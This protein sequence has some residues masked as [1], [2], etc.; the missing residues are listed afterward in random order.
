MPFVPNLWIWLVLCGFELADDCL[1]QKPSSP[2][3]PIKLQ[4]SISLVWLIWL[5]LGTQKATPF[6]VFPLLLK[7]AVRRETL[8][9]A[10]MAIART[11]VYVD[12]YLECKRFSIFSIP[13]KHFFFYLKKFANENKIWRKN[14]T[15]AN[16]LPAELQRLLN[17]I[18]ELD[19]RSQCKSNPFIF[20]NFF[21]F[22]TFLI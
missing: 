10:K 11:G 15:D 22:F 16:T 9:E 12:D 5:K 7:L 2:R 17:T 19:E 13:R 18:R 20:F 6:S 8:E 21:K 3:G 4:R 14:G 1:H